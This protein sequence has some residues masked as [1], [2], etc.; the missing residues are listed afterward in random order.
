MEKK[1]CVS[2]WR[3]VMHVPC[4]RYGRLTLVD[5]WPKDW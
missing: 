5:M 2:H 4:E 3:V 1:E